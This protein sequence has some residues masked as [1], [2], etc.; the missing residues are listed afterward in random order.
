M[1]RLI[2]GWSLVESMMNYDIRQLL[3]DGLAGLFP[4]MSAAALH[5]WPTPPPIRRNRCNIKST[6]YVLFSAH[7]HVWEIL[8]LVNSQIPTSPCLIT[9]VEQQSPLNLFLI[10]SL[11]ALQRHF[12]PKSTKPVEELGIPQDPR[13]PKPCRNQSSLHP[14][15][16]FFLITSQHRRVLPI[17]LSFLAKSFKQMCG[18]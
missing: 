7:R 4:I 12:S 6:C 13:W 2:D 10:N 14:G 1:L 5:A 11:F 18:T 15:W 3:G 9:D 17:K 16:S 8:N